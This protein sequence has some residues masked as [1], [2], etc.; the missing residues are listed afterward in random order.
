MENKTINILFV[1]LSLISIALSIAGYI[2]RKKALDLQSAEP[3]GC[4]DKSDDN[5]I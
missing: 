1:V 5:G 4:Q 3:C 2:Q